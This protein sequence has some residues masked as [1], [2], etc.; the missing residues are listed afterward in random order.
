MFHRI[1]SRRARSACALLATA[2]AFAAAPV[3]AQAGCPSSPSSKAFAQF[4]DEA[5]YVLATGGSFEAGTPGWSLHGASVAEGN[6]SYQVVS[7]THSLAIGSYGVATSPWTCVSSEYPTFRIFARRLSGTSSQPLQVNLRWIS[8]LGLN[9]E[10]GVAS[11]QSDGS[12]QPSPVMRLSRSL[13][14]WMPGETLQVQ[15]V[16]APAGGSSWAVD[17]VLLDPYSR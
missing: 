10:T 1:R 8:L 13:P 9:V 17:D 5:S 7:G 14:L 11:L 3:V 4:G 16:F 12:W 2:L 6:E 15:L